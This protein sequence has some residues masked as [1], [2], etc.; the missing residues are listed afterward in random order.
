MENSYNEIQ[1]I[2]EILEQFYTLEIDEL[3]N[4][5]KNIKRID[6]NSLVNLIESEKEKKYIKSRKDLVKYIKSI[7]QD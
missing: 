5:L 4:K 1:E 7:I 2:I 6:I 3:N